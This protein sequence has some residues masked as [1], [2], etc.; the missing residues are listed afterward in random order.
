MKK[1]RLFS[2]AVVVG[3]LAITMTTAAWQTNSSPFRVNGANLATVGNA[4][5]FEATVGGGGNVGLLADASNTLKLTQ[6]DGATKLG[7]LP[8]VQACGTATAC[9]LTQPSALKQVYGSCTAAGATTC[10]ITALPFTSTGSY[11]CFAQDTTTAANNALKV[12]NASASST[13][14]TTTSSSD[15]FNYQCIGT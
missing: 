6:N 5:I 12:A 2:L 14:I 10:T 1:K 7:S 13:V 3:L 8:A 15:V 11:F 4:L 9:S